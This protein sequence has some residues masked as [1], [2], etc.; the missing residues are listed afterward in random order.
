MQALISNLF[1]H[2]QPFS[3]MLKWKLNNNLK[4]NFSW[5]HFQCLISLC[6]FNVLSLFALHTITHHWKVN[7]WGS[8]ESQTAWITC[9]SLSG[10]L[11]TEQ[12]RN[13]HKEHCYFQ[14]NISN[15]NG[16]SHWRDI[17]KILKYVGRG[18]YFGHWALKFIMWNN[19]KKETG[20][21]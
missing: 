17:V 3:Q 12:E 9:P 6:P 4:I 20:S 2:P 21:I 7:Y 8:R 16:A 14:R 5:C 1:H 15:V 10:K 19:N 18:S 11:T 13:Q